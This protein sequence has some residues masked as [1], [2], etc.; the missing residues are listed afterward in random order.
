MTSYALVFCLFLAAFLG[1]YM[2]FKSKKEAIK[3]L[4]IEF[5]GKPKTELAVCKNIVTG[6]VNIEGF[7]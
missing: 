7:Y 2:L 1:G 6:T 4:N 5:E 3:V